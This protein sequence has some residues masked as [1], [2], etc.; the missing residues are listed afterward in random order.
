MDNGKEKK[1]I[2]LIKIEKQERIN[3]RFFMERIKQRWDEK[4]PENGL[5]KQNLRDNAARFKKDIKLMNLVLV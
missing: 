5:S 4:Y 1:K 3:G 2:E